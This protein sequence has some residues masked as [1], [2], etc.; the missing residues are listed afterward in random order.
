MQLITRH[1]IAA[2]FNNA[3]ANHRL[4]SACA[5]L[6]QEDFAATRVSFFP[7]IKATLNHTLTVGA[8]Y[9]DAMQRSLRGDAPHPDSRSFFDPEEQPYERCAELSEAQRALDRELIA[10]C[11]SLA[12]DESRLEHIVAVPR[13]HRIDS[14]PMNRLLAHLFEHQIHHRGQA[15]AMLAGTTVPPPQLDESIASTT[16][17]CSRKISGF[18]ASRR[19]PSGKPTRR[20][21]RRARRR[22][23][24]WCKPRPPFAN[25]CWA[26][27]RACAATHIRW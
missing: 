8:Y 24:P 7:S 3:W 10:L 23:N 5:Q 25:S 20:G 12:L 21:N 16:P 11:Q 19:R 6:T 18:W 4:L 15:H 17:R 14:E 27:S 22:V 1:L 13:T 2:A 9:L 26:R